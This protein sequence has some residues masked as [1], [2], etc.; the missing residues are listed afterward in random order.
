MPWVMVE[1]PEV[2]IQLVAVFVPSDKLPLEFAKNQVDNGNGIDCD[3]AFSYSHSLPIEN[4]HLVISGK[5]KEFVE[6]L[7][8]FVI[9]SE[10][11][12]H[13]DGVPRFWSQY[14]WRSLNVATVYYDDSMQSR[15]FSP[16]DGKYVSYEEALNIAKKAS[17]E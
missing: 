6:S 11:Q 16:F 3:G 4:A 9:Y 2:Y 7:D 15:H 5:D 17:N 12:S 1:K 13:L 14:G 10:I 8:T